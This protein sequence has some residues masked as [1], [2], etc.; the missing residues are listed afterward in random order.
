MPNGDGVSMR[1]CVRLG[2]RKE[3]DVLRC[4]VVTE[5][6]RKT[7]VVPQGVVRLRL[8]LSGVFN[9]ENVEKNKD[10]GVSPV[11]ESLRDGKFEYSRFYLE[12][13][14]GE[15]PFVNVDLNALCLV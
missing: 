5:K 3:P 12:I 6:L 7:I 2:F 9:F 4:D 15:R 8:I 13:P 10:A 14:H 11:P 1:H